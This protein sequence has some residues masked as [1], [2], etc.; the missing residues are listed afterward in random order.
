MEEVEMK[1]YKV[2]LCGF[3]PTIDRAYVLAENA[4][5]AHLKVKKWLYD[6]NR[7]SSRDRELKSIELLAEATEYPDVGTMLFL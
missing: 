5:A 4:E 6:K 2:T 1:L 3:I 7:G